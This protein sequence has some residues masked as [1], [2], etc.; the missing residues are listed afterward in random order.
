MLLISKFEIIHI[1]MPKLIKYDRD[2]SII[3]H[4]IIFV[5]GNKEHY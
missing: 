1:S 3:Y 2:I 5:S 4:L